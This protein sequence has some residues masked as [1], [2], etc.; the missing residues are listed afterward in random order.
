[1][2]GMTVQC[3]CEGCEENRER[4]P[5]DSLIGGTIVKWGGE[6]WTTRIQHGAS[7]LHLTSWEPSLDVYYP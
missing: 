2:E 7:T 6:W 4:P 5:T 3:Q 1:M